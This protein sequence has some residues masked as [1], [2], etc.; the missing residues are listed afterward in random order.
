M[1]VEIRPQSSKL[2]PLVNIASRKSRRY[3]LIL[4]GFGYWAFQTSPAALG[5]TTF[6]VSIGDNFFNPSS[7]TISVND[8]VKWTWNGANSHSS[9]SDTGIWNSGIGG[10]GM[11]FSRT[12]ASA[13]SFP[14]HCNVH[15]GQLGSVT[16]Q[17][18][19]NT[20]PSVSITNPAN[21]AV[22]SAP[23]AFP[24]QATA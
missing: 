3:A 11:T 22:F 15:S 19:V 4:L 24:I 9:T 1:Q 10:N 17:A 16:V 12:F 5:A 18:A 8:I 7:V 21:G 13:G 2:H 14:Y 23:G 6:N 20:P